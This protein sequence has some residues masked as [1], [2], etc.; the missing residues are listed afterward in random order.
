VF[1]VAAQIPNPDPTKPH[2]VTH[3][4]FKGGAATPES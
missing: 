2:M 3:R 1:Y 4:E